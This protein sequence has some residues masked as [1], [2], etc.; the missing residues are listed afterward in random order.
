[1]QAKHK[2]CH[3]QNNPKKILHGPLLDWNLFHRCNFCYYVNLITMHRQKR[4]CTPELNENFSTFLPYSALSARRSSCPPASYRVT[5]IGVLFKA[6]LTVAGM[7]L[8]VPLHA[9][10]NV[11][12]ANI[13]TISNPMVGE[14]QP[15][16]S[17][18]WQW[19]IAKHRFLSTNY[20]N[21]L[22]Y[23]GEHFPFSSVKWLIVER[24]VYKK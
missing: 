20:D 17:L 23:E 21:S 19:T 8:Y 4:L 11:S 5:L 13:W 16:T 22:F 18:A 6:T 1:M 3:S 14:W 24:P 12:N 7:E 15:L 9:I 2:K 10:H